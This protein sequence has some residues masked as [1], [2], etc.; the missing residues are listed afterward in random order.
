MTKSACLAASTGSIAG[1]PGTDTASARPSCS[2][3]KPGA[4]RTRSRPSRSTKAA[5]GVTSRSVWMA[6]E[7]PRLLSGEPSTIEWYW[8]AFGPMSATLPI[9]FASRGRKPPAFFSN[10]ALSTAT[11]RANARCPAERT[12]RSQ[13]ACSACSAGSSRSKAPMRKKLRRLRRVASSARLAS[14]TPVR[15]C[16]TSRASRLASTLLMLSIVEPAL[17]D[18]TVSR[19]PPQSE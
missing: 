15:T 19:Q 4:K 9:V 11:R 13:A 6:P 3:R 2:K 16:P 10:T 12:L 8:S 7:P 17:R 1:S 14:M 18:L 5:K